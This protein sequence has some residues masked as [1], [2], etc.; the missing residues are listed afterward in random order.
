MASF[1]KG[2]KEG[3]VSDEDKEDFSDYLAIIG[4][5]M[6]LAKLVFGKSV[7]DLENPKLRTFA[8]SDN[9]GAEV[10]LLFYT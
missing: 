8:A 10:H 7:P 1:K 4:E 3:A 9:F 5:R 6:D 2:E